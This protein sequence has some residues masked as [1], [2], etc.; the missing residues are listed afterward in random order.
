M[1]LARLLVSEGQTPAASSSC[2]ARAA[3]FGRGEGAHPAHPIRWCRASTHDRAARMECWRRSPPAAS[4]H[5]DQRQ[6]RRAAPAR[7]GD[8]VVIGPPNSC[9][10][11]MASR[12]PRLEPTHDEVGSAARARPGAHRRITAPRNLGASA[13]PRRPMRTESAAGR[14]A[15]SARRL[16]CRAGALG[17]SASSCYTSPGRAG[18][19]RTVA[20]RD[21]HREPTRSQAA[22]RAGR[23]SCTDRTV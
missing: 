23:R 8:E 21:R 9:S 14:D 2:A 22:V 12:H 16:R 11:S 1:S 13:D 19:R 15:V 17:A 3:W 6:A 20:R 4:A 7:A 18:R 10:P 5:A